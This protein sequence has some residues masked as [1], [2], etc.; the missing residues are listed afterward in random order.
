LA[1]IAAIDPETHVGEI[2]RERS[3]HIGEG[4]FGS[5]TGRK[6]PRGG[7]LQAGP[8]DSGD[9]GGHHAELEMVG[10]LIG[11]AR[12]R[13]GTA[14]ILLDLSESGVDVHALGI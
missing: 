13:M 2:M 11:G 7:L 12:L 6:T 9:G 1:G 8:V 3:A 4:I 10:D 14:D 5:A